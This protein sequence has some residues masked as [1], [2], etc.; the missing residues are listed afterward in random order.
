MINVEGFGTTKKPIIFYADSPST[1]DHLKAWIYTKQVA[2]NLPM[3]QLQNIYFEAE[4]MEIYELMN[5]VMDR[6]C[7]FTLLSLANSCSWWQAKRFRPRFS[8]WL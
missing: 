1:F 2:A 6:K 4:R 8:P 5:R 3:H 7:T